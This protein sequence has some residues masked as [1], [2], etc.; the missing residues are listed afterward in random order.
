MLNDLRFAVRLLGRSPVLTLV[1]A[2]SL[3]L[4]IG[5][6]TTVFTL[7]N[8][9]F[10]RPLPLKE[11]S[12]LVSIFTAD[13]RNRQNAFGSFMPVSRL[14]FEDFRSKNT[15]LEGLA[16]QAFTAVSLTGGSGEPEQIGAEIVSA[17]Y[18]PLLGSPAAVGRT[19][20]A[21]EQNTV[22]AAPVTVLSYGLW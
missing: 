8:Q 17:D 9:V 2:L 12:R 20:S 22:G 14:N 6:N 7:V 18:F 4:G 5:A 13:E 15:S 16:A 11:P 21:E 10:L 1:A 3:G 19:F